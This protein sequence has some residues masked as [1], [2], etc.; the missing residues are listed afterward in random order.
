MVGWHRFAS[1]RVHGIRL[2]D[3]V[4]VLQRIPA[5]RGAITKAGPEAF[6]IVPVEAAWACRHKP[7][8]GATRRRWQAGLPAQTLARSWKA[9][10]HL[11][12]AHRPRQAARVAVTAVARELAGLGWA[13]IG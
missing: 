5:P 1:A 12:Q 10:S 6:L 2:A 4:G 3:P 8:I 9:P 13:E 11:P 7:A